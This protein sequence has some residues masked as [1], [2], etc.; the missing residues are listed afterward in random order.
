ME[1]PSSVN[2]AGSF[3]H[4]SAHVVAGPLLR[5]PALAAAV[6][7]VSRWWPEDLH[8]PPSWPGCPDRA[9]LVET[10]RCHIADTN[11]IPGLSGPR[12]SKIGR[13]INS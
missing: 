9:A 6:G 3:H 7:G 11:T 5:P 13:G 1:A 4:K 12:H 2:N 10:L 8:P